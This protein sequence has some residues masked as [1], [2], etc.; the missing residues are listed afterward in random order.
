MSMKNIKLKIAAWFIVYTNWTLTII[1]IVFY[2]KHLIDIGQI[3]IWMATDWNKYFKAAAILFVI[4]V[5]PYL[6]VR[7]LSSNIIFFFSKKFRSHSFF[8]KRL[9]VK[10]T[11]ENYVF[12]KAP[13]FH[14]THPELNFIF[15]RLDRLYEKL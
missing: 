1:G 10:T 13:R 14:K 15:K 2:S 12:F 5:V 8:I 7:F 3:E 6:L 11:L 9:I 4:C